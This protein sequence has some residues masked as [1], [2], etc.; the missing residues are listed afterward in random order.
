[1]TL[2]ADPN[3]NSTFEGWSGACGGTNLI[4]SVTMD[5]SK[6]VTATFTLKPMAILTVSKTGDGAGTV[7]GP[8]I[9]CDT[10]NTDCQENYDVGSNVNLS[11]TAALGSIFVGWTGCDNVE[12]DGTCTMTM[13]GDKTLMAEFDDP[14]VLATSDPATSFRVRLAR[15]LV[16]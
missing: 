1:V 13:S 14:L 5:G 4:C 9:D 15:E 8:G 6:S 11:A 10:S 3:P 12:L 7:S 16:R 2:K